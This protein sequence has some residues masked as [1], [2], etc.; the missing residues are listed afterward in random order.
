M[1]NIF[2]Y[3]QKLQAIYVNSFISAIIVFLSTVYSFYN[4]DILLCYIKTKIRRFF[5]NCI[6][7]IWG[8]S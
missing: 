1:Y 8:N 2:A 6:T 7:F 4:N 5:L 3:L